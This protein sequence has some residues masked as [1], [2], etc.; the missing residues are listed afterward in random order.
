MSEK[1]F[2]HLHLHT[3][4]S[5]LDGATRID[6]LFDACKEKN[7]PAVAITDHGNMYGAYHFYC[8]AKKKG[9]KP[10]IGCEF[11]MADDLTVKSGDVKREFNHLVLIAKNN[12]GYKNL[13]KLNS[14]GFVDGYYYKPRIDFKTLSQHSEGLIC[15]SACIAGQLPR[16]LRDGM[17]EEARKLVKQY[18]ELFGE[19][20]YIEL[21]DH[22]IADEIYVMPKLI[23]IAEEFGVEL[24][25]T[26]DVH[27][28]K[29]SDAEMQD[30]LLCVQ[31]GKFFDDPGRMRFEGTQFYLKDYDEM[32]EKFS[33]VPQ[34]L[35]NTLKIAE[36]C[37][38]SIEKKPLLP[39]YKPDNGMTPYEFLKDLLEK[40]LKRRYKEI[41]P[42]IRQRADYELEVVSKMGFV[43]YYLIV[44]DF[45]NYAHEHGIPVGP[46]RG[47][48]AG[49][50]IAYAIGIT[51]VEPLRYGLIFERF[52]NPERVSMPDFDIDFCMDRRGEVIDY[53][54][55]KYTK[56]RVA[57]IVTFGRMKAKNAVKDVCRVLRVPYAEGD[58]ITKLIPLNATLKNAFGLD[59][60]NEGVPELMEIYKDY[61]MK[62]VI[63]LAIA[64]EDMPRQ[65]GMHAAGVVICRED[66]SDNVPLQRSGDDITTQYNMK[67]VEELGLLKMDFLGLRTLTDIDK[68]IK[69]VKETTGE[70]F[71]FED[72]QYDDPNVFELIASGN[73]DAVFQLESG[74][75]KRVMKDLKPDCLEDIIAGISLYRPGPMQFI[76]DYIKGKRDP[77]SV[78][79]AHPMLEPILGVT[80]GC[81]V[82]QEQVMQIC[83]SLAGYS[84]GQADEVRRAMGKKKMD[85]MALHRNYFI[86]GKVNDNGEVEIEGAVRRG[87]P[88]E[89]AELL[90]DQMYAF[91]QYAFNKSHAAAYAYVSYQTAYCKRYHPVEYLAAVLNNRITNIDDI[92]N[93]SLTER[94]TT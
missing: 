28:L 55:E 33:Y 94:R 83:R 70:E 24:V 52:L 25:A 86:N 69:I 29:E 82:Y 72:C 63:D 26:N 76:P 60:K 21:Q 49:S 75:M 73:T 20:Y 67:E 77:K 4:Y 62:R 80:N 47:S 87:V 59:G 11:Y 38:V 66:L 42:E 12:T 64:L 35:E 79:Y 91:A 41:T 56:P 45:I 10:I 30:I 78:H 17:W 18:K 54:I 16:L 9:I 85:V 57:Q 36:K 51:Q 61:S 8:L 22:G 3:E 74:G 92:K 19:D 37:N 34:A 40:G 23:K 88:K 50:I 58:K 89:T 44:W 32:A 13:V 93:I 14:I 2:V 46:G 27:Y 71:D 15:L 39:P 90:F 65:T 84:Y 68:T 1:P 81:M 7:M 43:E 6:T 31:T 5:L 53:V 48:G